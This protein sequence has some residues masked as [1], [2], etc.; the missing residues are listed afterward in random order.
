MNARCRICSANDRAALIEEIAA[1]IWDSSRDPEIDN[2]SWADAGATWQ[3]AMRRHAER[4]L[5]VA[6]RPV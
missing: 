2:R 4:V 3:R 5:A 6:E 1:E